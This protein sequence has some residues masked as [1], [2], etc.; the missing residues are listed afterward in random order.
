MWDCTAPSSD[1]L[2]D[3]EFIAS[4]QTHSLT[5]SWRLSH[6]KAGAYIIHK[7]NHKYAG[8]CRHVMERLACIPSKF[9]ALHGAYDFPINFCSMG[10]TSILS[11]SSSPKAGTALGKVLMLPHGVL[12]LLKEGN[13]VEILWHLPVGSPGDVFVYTRWLC[14]QKAKTVFMLWNRILVILWK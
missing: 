3:P 9:H 7:D 2:L 8:S 10:H 4:T 11:H 1:K 13:Q 6:L 5:P 14:R 12:L